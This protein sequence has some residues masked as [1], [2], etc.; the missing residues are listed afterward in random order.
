MLK[1]SAHMREFP[2]THNCRHVLA[3]EHLLKKIELVAFFPL[4][5]IRGINRKYICNGGMM[6]CEHSWY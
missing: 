3:F 1:Y 4:L 6:G 2:K 5:G